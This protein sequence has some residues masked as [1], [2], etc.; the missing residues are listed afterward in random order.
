MIKVVQPGHITSKSFK[1]QKYVEMQLKN[2][3]RIVSNTKGSVYYYKKGH[4]MNFL[5]PMTPFFWDEAQITISKGANFFLVMTFGTGVV[6]EYRGIAGEFVNQQGKMQQNEVWKSRD[7]NLINV[8]LE[9]VEVGKR[10]RVVIAIKGLDVLTEEV[11]GWHMRLELLSKKAGYYTIH[12]P[13]IKREWQWNENYFSEGSCLEVMVDE[14]TTHPAVIKEKSADGYLTLDVNGEQMEHVYTSPKLRPAGTTSALST[15]LASTLKPGETG[16]ERSPVPVWSF[17]KLQVPCGFR[18]LL[19]PA[20][21]SRPGQSSDQERPQNLVTACTGISFPSVLYAKQVQ[22]RDSVEKIMFTDGKWNFPMTAL[23]LLPSR[24]SKVDMT[25][26]SQQSLTGKFKLHPLCCFRGDVNTVLSSGPCVPQLKTLECYHVVHMLDNTGFEL[27]NIRL[28]DSGETPTAEF[29]FDQVLSGQ[30]PEL[31]LLWAWMIMVLRLQHD[32]LTEIKKITKDIP[33]IEN[34][35]THQVNSGLRQVLTFLS[36]ALFMSFGKDFQFKEI[37]SEATIELW[38]ALMLQ[39]GESQ[40]L[41]RV[42]QLFTAES[43]LVCESHSAAW[44]VNRQLEHFSELPGLYPQFVYSLNLSGNKISDLPP[45]LFTSMPNLKDLCVSNNRISSIPVEIGNCKQLSNLAIAENNLKDLP[46]TLHRCQDI[47][48]LDME[49]NNFTELPSVVLKLKNLKR[50][51]AQHLQLLSLPENIGDLDNLETLSLSGN[52]LTSLPDSMRKMQKLTTLSMNGVVWLKSRSNSLLSRENFEDFLKV[53]NLHQW[54]DRRNQDKSSIFQLFDEDTNGTLDSREIGKLNA[55]MFHI[56]PRFG[57]MGKQQPD[58]DTPSGFPEVLFELKNL[59]YLSLQFL[60]IVS[61]PEDIK[62]LT[63]LSTL[64]LGNNPNLLTISAHVGSL[65]LKR[66]ELEACPRLKTPPKEIRAKGFVT[67]MAYLKRLVTGSVTCHRTKLMLVGLGGAGKTSL[68]RTLLSGGKTKLTMEEELTDGIDISSWSVPTEEGE[69]TFSVWDFAGQTVYYNTHQF[70]LSDRAVYL[71]LWNIRLGHEH[72]GLQFWLSSVSVHAPKAPI[73]VVGTHL[74]KMSKVELPIIELQKK[75]PQII[76]FHFVSSLTGQGIEELKKQLIQETLKQQYIGEKIPGVWLS[77]EES[78]KSI[79]DRNVIEYKELET[80]ANRSGIFDSTE[81]AQAV[82]FLH[83]LGSLQHFSNANLKS[84]VV[85]NPQWIVDVMACVVSVKDSHIKDGRLLH[86]ELSKVWEKYDPSLYTWLLKLTEEFDLTFPLKDE[87][88]NLVPCL[89]PEVQPQFDWP[90]LHKNSFEK[91]TKIVYKFDYLPAGLFNRGQVR[92]HQFSDSALIW[93]RGSYLKKNGH[94]CLIQQTQE[95]ELTVRAHGPHPDNVVLLVHEMFESLIIESFQGIMYDFFLPCPDCMSV[96]AKDPHMFPASIIRRAT[97]LKSPFLQCLKYFH[98]ISMTDLHAIMPPDNNQDFDLHLVQAVRGMKELQKDLIADIF[99]C[100]CEKDNVARDKESVLPSRVVE[101]V[102]KTGYKCW[103]PKESESIDEMAKALVDVKIFLVFMSNNFVQDELCCNLFKYARLTLRKPII[104]VAIG[105]NTEWTK[106]NM[107]ILV[108]DEVYVNMMKASRYNHKMEELTAMLKEKHAIKKERSRSKHYPP[109]F[110]SYSWLNSAQ[111]VAKG[112]R[113]EE[114]AIGYGDPREIKSFL[115]QNG[116]KCWIDVERVGAHGLF[117]DIGEGLINC[118]VVVVCI[119]DEYT[120]SENCEREFRY[121]ANTLKL[122]IVLA[123]VGTGNKWRAKEL[124]I[125]SLTYPLV[126]FQEKSETAMGKL[127]ELVRSNIPNDEQARRERKSERKKRKKDDENKQIQEQKRLSFQELCE[128]AQRKFLR[129]VSQYADRIDIIPYPNLM[130]V[131][132]CPEEK[133]Q[134]ENPEKHE[135]ETNETKRPQIERKFSKLSAAS[136]IYDQKFCVYLLCEHEEG[137]HTSGNPILLDS[138]FGHNFDKYLPYVAR[139]TAIAKFSKKI[140]LN[141]LTS[142]IGQKYLKLLEESP[143]VALTADLQESY[144]ELRQMVLE[145]DAAHVKGKLERCLL[146][147][148]KHIWLCEAHR[149]NARVTVMSRE[150]VV[151][152]LQ[153][154]SETLGVDHM[155]QALQELDPLALPQK[156]RL[157]LA[158]SEG[159]L[160]V[161]APLKSSPAKSSIKNKTELS[162]PVSLQTGVSDDNKQEKRG[163]HSTHKP[164]EENRPNT[165]TSRAC[166]VM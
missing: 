90:E 160:Q 96:A 131:D 94:I 156:L 3:D 114:G 144:G 115:E 20:V 30:S 26:C 84:H 125:L 138:K 51:Y 64:H 93:K 76:G 157:S 129:Q 17:L 67:T 29:D 13:G 113:K 71:L 24:L 48:R 42:S 134:E 75:Y 127:L 44:Q 147:S 163:E 100:F 126:S 78:I 62:K 82:Q 87:P 11:D 49:K 37:I 116:I 53:N 148:G 110:I 15:L 36:Q 58:D 135:T 60:G 89:L 158:G 32:D 111:A 166:I 4:R 118:Q 28:E 164:Q 2:D 74:D 105:E 66:L 12:T 159:N 65:P 86:S 54:L 7:A 63:K 33:K 25:A 43:I 21:N 27:D 124:G 141:S 16:V 1:L 55:T 10:V 57:Y 59:Q 91:E 83:E 142:E 46:S 18:A 52:C 132:L 92:L 151:N 81:V 145:V 22:L 152:T 73:F 47:L 140:V 72:A 23:M 50:L 6:L 155:L 123:I 41:V 120:V 45:Q 122:P 99:V 139:I 79:H 80:K 133:G 161:K 103:K 70:F 39:F 56:F 40:G 154:Q 150:S 107:G 106:S 98:T 31:G 119:S 104:L 108:V 77:F 34:V 137:W 128:L 14:N 146:P 19:T 109:C 9:S 85:I 35:S 143:T 136:E 149:K 61:V 68:V 153:H 102:E 117:E 5:P 165:A 38:S 95:C 69:L 88:V 121:A 112:S 162:Q 8:R 130:M 97:E 101:D